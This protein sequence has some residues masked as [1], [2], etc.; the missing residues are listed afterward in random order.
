MN[1]KLI[2]AIAGVIVMAGCNQPA[3]KEEAKQDI[4]RNDMDT[5]VR[6]N[7]DFFAYANGRW[8]KNNP[9]PGD[10]TAWGIGE[11]VQKKPEP[12]SA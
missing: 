6:P 2:G 12:A 11:L 8:I 7:D 1:K 4:I 9:I 10:E 5:T 3:P